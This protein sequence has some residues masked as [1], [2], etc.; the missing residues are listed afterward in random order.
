MGYLVLARKYRPGTFEGFV[1]QDIIAETLKNAI[2]LDRVAHAYLF[3]GPRGVGKTSM[4]RV[5]AKAL[6]CVKGPTDKPCDKCEQCTAISSGQDVDVIEIDGA[7]NNGVEEVRD[8]TQ[9]SR[10]APAHSRFKI[11]YVD[12]VHMLSISAFNALLKTLEEPPQHVKFIFAT[13]AASKLPE[14]ILSRVQRF[15]FRRISNLDIVKK[16]TE[17]CKAEKLAVPADVMAL[18]ARRARGSM[19]DAL[20]LLDQ[21]IS[22]CGGKPD[23]DA[24]AG[25]LGAL[26]DDEMARLLK[27]IC[28]KDAA[29]LLKTASELLARG[30]D[31]GDLLDQMTG[32]V[33]DV[34]VGQSCGADADLL[35]RAPEGAAAIVAVGKGL[36]A[37]Q[38]LYI[39]EILNGARRRIREGQDDRIVLEMALVKLAQS[40]GLASV[41]ELIERLTA[42]EEGGGKPAA[43]SPPPRATAAPY[44]NAQA[45]AS[46]PAGSPQRPSPP[47]SRPTE[48]DEGPDAAAAVRED[49]P[50]DAA[51]LWRRFLDEVHKNSW[52]YAQVAAGRLQRA[53]DGEIVIAFPSDRAAAREEADKLENR[54]KLQQIFARLL[55]QPVKLTI[56]TVQGEP[57][58]QSPAAAGKSD[59]IVQEIMQKY[60]GQIIS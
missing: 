50:A 38:L 16:L 27:L 13:T 49:A 17:I 46:R 42:L 11:Y 20:S 6:N 21:I 31:V 37:D 44:G 24:V 43:A 1:G 2:K 36:S 45:P 55:N 10:Y 52:L 3:C 8:I 56:V 25:L 19:R 15:D 18:T 58:R 7:S 14:T 40:D 23:R 32:Y 48:S 4:A 39:A 26:G 53:K 51:D 57:A 41:G 29:G 59:E 5:F 28:E 22:F 60:D 47:A 9:N 30:M 54:R 35:D 33:R 34:L 12:E